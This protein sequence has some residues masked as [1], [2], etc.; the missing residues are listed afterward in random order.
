MA[1]APTHSLT[2]LRK[3]EDHLTCPVCLV[4][5]TDPRVLQCMHTFCRKC[6]EKLTKRG[7][8]GIVECPTCRKKTEFTAIEELQRAFYLESLFEIKRDLE[9]SH[10]SGT[11]EKHVKC[12][13]HNVAVESYC[14]TCKQFLC[15]L[16]VYG[17]HK[18]HSF[19]DISIQ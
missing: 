1:T 4:A 17:E 10:G 13:T 11:S 3:L 5:Y 19:D 6:L 9:A 12:L 15:N 7:T 16:C 14:K 8:Q 18:D 2:A